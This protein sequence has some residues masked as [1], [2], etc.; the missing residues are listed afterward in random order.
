[1]DE[2]SKQFASRELNNNSKSLYWSIRKCHLILGYSFACNEVRQPKIADIGGG[3]GYMFDW[4]RSVFPG[5]TARWTVFESSEVANA[6]SSVPHESD[7]EFVSSKQLDSSARFNLTI[8]SSTLQYLED[9][10]KFLELS[11]S[12]SQ[13]VLLMRLP[14]ID[15]PTNQVF[16]QKPKLGLYIASDASWPITLFSRAQFT[17]IVQARAN[18]VFVAQ[19]FEETSFFEWKP[20]AVRDASLEAVLKL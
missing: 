4:V 7:I 13:F 18:P 14:L 8:L 19:D 11:L 6:Y 5:T 12:V 3:N 2:L 16:I 20:V 15:S 9:W 10:K 17:S 1:V